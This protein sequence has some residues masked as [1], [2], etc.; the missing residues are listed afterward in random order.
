MGAD[1]EMRTSVLAGYLG[2]DLRKL[3]KRGIPS[4]VFRNELVTVVGNYTSTPL[5]TSAELQSTHL[6]T[7]PTQDREAEAYLPTLIRHG[8]RCQY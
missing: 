1:S 4:V 5:R 8:L 3:E 2:V 7:V 6:T